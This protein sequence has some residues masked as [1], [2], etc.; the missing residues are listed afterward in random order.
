[1]GKVSKSEIDIWMKVLLYCLN[2]DCSIRILVVHK[3]VIDAETKVSKLIY[4]YKY[5]RTNDEQQKQWMYWGS[6]TNQ[7]IFKIAMLQK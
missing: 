2:S 7:M 6:L 3:S 5:I 1:M 4:A